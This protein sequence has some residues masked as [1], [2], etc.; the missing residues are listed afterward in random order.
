MDDDRSVLEE[1]NLEIGRRESAGDRAGLERIIAPA[2]AFQRANPE[3]TVVD[4]TGYLESVAQSPPR[5]TEVTSVTVHG[6]RAVVE[7]FVTME[8]KR[9]HNLRLFIR[10]EGRW[11]LLGWANEPASA[12]PAP[13]S[14]EAGVG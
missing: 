9:F 5:Q 1:L 11:K 14:V 8:G 2:L 12:D 10:H 6:S 13:A 7:C 4:R 3:R